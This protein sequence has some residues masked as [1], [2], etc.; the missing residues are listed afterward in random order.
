MFNT[1]K[2]IEFLHIPIVKGFYC[3]LERVLFDGSVYRAP[4]EILRD[5][6]VDPICGAPAM[7]LIPLSSL[8]RK[9]LRDSLV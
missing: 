8:S 2:I 4:H 5:V 1:R 3:D 6:V 7:G 9:C